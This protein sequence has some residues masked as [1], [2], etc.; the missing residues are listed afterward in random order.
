M[1]HWEFY[2]VPTSIVNEKCGHNKTIAIGRV[3]EITPD[4]G[5]VSY[6]QLKEA[7]DKALKI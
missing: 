6:R 1:S 2:V 3:K 7:I 4:Y 5:K